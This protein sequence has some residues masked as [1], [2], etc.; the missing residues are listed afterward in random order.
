MRRPKLRDVLTME[1]LPS[2]VVA[3]DALNNE[4]V[5]VVYVLGD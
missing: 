5:L 2:G 4:V 1:K 3:K